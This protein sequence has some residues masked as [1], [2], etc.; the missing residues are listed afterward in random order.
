MLVEQ[1]IRT[2]IN[3]RPIDPMDE[4]ECN[5][6]KIGQYIIYA[7]LNPDPLG[8]RPYS[9]SGWAV[10]PGSFWYMGLPE[11]MNDLQRICNAVIRSLVNNLSISSGPQVIIDD[12]T[13]LAGGQKI[14]SMRPWKIWQ[15]VNTMRSQIKAVDF[16]QPPNNAEALLKV[17]DTFSQLADDWTGIPALA[18]GSVPPGGIGRTSS[19]L[20]MLMNSSARGIRNVIA[21]VDRE[22]VRPSV[23]RQ[24]DWN[25]V[26]DTDDSIKGDVGIEAKGA[27]AIIVKEQMAAQRMDFLTATGNPLDQRIMGVSGRANVLREAAEALQMDT[28]EVI[29]GKEGIAQIEQEMAQERQ[30]QAMSAGAQGG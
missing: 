20:A 24:Y 2:Q 11:L 1:G 10:I 25:M 16:F 7:A 21:R 4:Y 26:Y 14:T 28:T 18:H 30:M 5:V 3:N 6:I 23:L 9:K 22:I 13:R 19:G 8:R 12:I 15:F 27:V 17:W 29:P